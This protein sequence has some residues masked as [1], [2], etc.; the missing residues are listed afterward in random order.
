MMLIKTDAVMRN[1]MSEIIRNV[2]RFDGKNR[3]SYTNTNTSYNNIIDAQANNGPTSPPPSQVSFPAH[4]NPQ[5]NLSTSSCH[6]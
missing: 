2:H 5:K 6:R 3:T 4:P 1:M